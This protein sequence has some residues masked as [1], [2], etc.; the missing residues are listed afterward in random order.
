MRRFAFCVA[1][2]VVL[3]GVLS[4]PR[5]AAAG[6]RCG[7]TNCEDGTVCCNDTCGYCAPPDGACIQP[8]C[9]WGPDR[10]AGR[11]PILALDYPVALQGPRMGVAVG[12][13]TGDTFYGGQLRAAGAKPLGSEFRL[14]GGLDMTQANTTNTPANASQ[15]IIG[16]DG[17]ALCEVGI[18][19]A[20]PTRRPWLQA[21]VA[22]DGIVHYWRLFGLTV[23]APPVRS[24]RLA[25]VELAPGLVVVAQRWGV[26]SSAFVRGARQLKC[27]NLACDSAVIRLWDMGLSLDTDGRSLGVPVG[28]LVH[29]RLT[30][31]GN[32][33]GAGVFWLGQRLRVGVE[34]RTSIREGTLATSWPGTEWNLR[35][36]WLP[37]ERQ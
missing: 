21:V 14:H 33:V 6:E 16:R 5:Q 22:L 32:D 11:R 35:M 17:F 28:L 23:S 30:T 2:L 3:A 18:G 8:D 36:D 34:W 7:P 27:D 9:G 24:W 37:P 4:T 13:G 31:R 10:V 26:G 12:S 20:L 29:G 25:G 1:L 15:V 19:W